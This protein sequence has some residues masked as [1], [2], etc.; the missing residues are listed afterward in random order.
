MPEMPAFCD[1]C[2]AV[3][4]SGFVFESCRNVTLSGTQAGPCPNCGGIG[5][6]PDGVYDITGNAIKLLQGSIKT[7]EQ[8][9]QL[10]AVLVEAQKKNLSKEQVQTNI[11]EAVPELTGFASVLPQT[12]SELY[13]FI[14]IILAAI[15]LLITAYGTFKDEPV[16]EKEIEHI[17]ERSIEKSIQKL[18]P[19]KPPAPK[20]QKRNDPCACGSGVKYKKCCYLTA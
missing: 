4:G 8:L 19:P 7:I 12:R 2:G 13:G 14:G 17:I 3:F 6:V 18:A 15:G 16:P 11:Q 20:K 1:N 9:Q 5:H 10:S